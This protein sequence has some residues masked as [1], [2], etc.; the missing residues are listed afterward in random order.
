M[1]SFKGST[2]ET[3]REA[4]EVFCREECPYYPTCV[5]KAALEPVCEGSDFQ[6]LSYKKEC[7]LGDYIDS[8]EYSMLM[9]Y[10][11]IRYSSSQEIPAI[12]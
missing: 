7:W 4:F 11:G 10:T 1:Y 12:E 5:S 8:T 9:Y 2:Y 6:Y 3:V